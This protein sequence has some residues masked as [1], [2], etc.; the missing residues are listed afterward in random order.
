MSDVGDE[1]F[2]QLA[3]ACAE[4]RQAFDRF[5]G[6][7]QPRRLLLALLAQEGELRHADVQRRLGLDGATITRLVKEFER[8][9][10]LTRR[11]DPQDNRYTLV[12][13]TV[14]G[15]R[16]I[17][18]LAEAHRHFQGQLLAGIPRE[19]QAAVIRALA[20]LRA[21]GDALRDETWTQGDVAPARRDVPEGDA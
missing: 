4:T 10:V 20:A 6:M 19:E 5:S 18:D 12:A 11:L 17:A 16:L 21:N 9:R 14:E 7:S 8:A 1:F 15:R 2:R 3:A 13:A